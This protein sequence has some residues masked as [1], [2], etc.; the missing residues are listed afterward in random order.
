MKIIDVSLRRPVTVLILTIAILVLGL[1]SYSNMGVERM[2][3]IDF[4]IVV[5]QT[6][7]DGASPAIM[8]NDVTDVLEARINTIEGIKNISSSSYEG[9]SVI[10]VEFDL[11]R[12]V[13]F[14]AADV[15]GKV[16]M[17]KGQLP[18]ECDDPQVDKF[19]PSNMPIMNI[20]I[21]TDGHS[22]AKAVARFVDNV[23]TERLQT[24]T[25]VGGVQLAGFRDREIRIWLNTDSLEAY[26]LTTKDIK[27]AV[28]NRHVELPA[29]R[30]ET[31]TR[32][33]GIRLNGEYRSVAELSYVPVA[34]RNGAII[35]LRD[36]A[37]IED[38]VEDKRSQ[39][40]YEN[41]PTIMVQVRKQKGA[42]E[43]AL[44]SEV[45]KRIVELNEI[46]PR[47]S[48]LVIV[49]DTSR[50]ILRSM[51]G[52]RGDIILAIFLTSLIMF[53]F[54]RTI[55]A[56]IIAVITIP[57]CLLGS[58]AVLYWMG[59]TINNISMMGMSL[60]VGMVVDATSV[61]M[62]NISRHKAMGK[63]PMRAA[64]DGAGEVGFAVVA[65]A[66]TTLAVFIPIAFMRGVM[67][68]FFNAFGITVA[69]TI[70][71][72]L[73]L[74]LT[75]TPFLCSRILG[76][77]RPGF[78]QNALE[79]PF[80]M[81]ERGYR[82]LLSF[83]VNHRLIVILAALATF[84]GGIWIATTLGSE[85]TP[86]EDQGYFRL[87][88]EMP[89]DTS[90]EV[91]ERVMSEMISVVEADPRVAY[92]Y[93]VAGSG[94]GQEVYKGSLT[95]ELIPKDQR[96][97][98]SVIMGQLRRK[99]SAFRDVDIKMGNWGGSDITLMI[100][101]PTSESLAEIGDLIKSDLA[102][103]PRG[104]VDITTD[105][106]M[107]K[108]RINLELNRALADDLGV[109]IRDLSD[110]LNAWF[111]GTTSGSF[112]EGG[113]RYDIRIRAEKD[114][115]DDPDKVF[116]TLVRTAGGQV[117]R[118]DGL[119]TSSIG[120]SPNVIKRYNRQR[121]IQIGANVEGISPSEGIAIME[122]VFRKYAPQD[123]TYNMT[124]TGD[125]ERMRESFANMAIALVFA[126]ML[127]YIVMA[128][129][130]ESFLHP[131]TVMFSLP[132]MTAGSFGL[133]YLAN[134]RISVMSFMGII[135]LVGVVVNNAILLVDFI[136]QLRAGG[137]KKVEAVIESG[138]LRL[139]AILMTTVST[140]VGNLPVA[141]A[142]SEGGEIR[143][144]MSVAV[145]GGLFTSTLLTLLVIPVIYL[146]LDDIKDW[147]AGRIHRYR[148][149]RRLREMHSNRPQSSPTPA[150][151]SAAVAAK[152]MA[153]PSAA[154]VE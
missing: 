13:D 93:G 69:M 102:S 118:A 111:A 7:M 90:L 67:G 5:V 133:M 94:Q 150:G 18:D 9:R 128:I 51:N 16:S 49:S 42:N 147:V 149:Y 74:S 151:A 125:S 138:P 17:A 132:L 27:D 71:I 25:G 134:L 47:G 60:A 41:S 122:D 96:E 124:P 59:I 37:R 75:L 23:V 81:L 20:A 30:I 34:Y 50:F 56:T 72:S 107:N 66:A 63:N 44:A 152:E 2:P 95:I 99:L 62:E 121:S 139:R 11:D 130:F 104:L 4:P 105:L 43:V 154:T 131:F 24:V 106:Q 8:D 33:Y 123:G 141:L 83:A 32:E 55:R 39:S 73:L 145:T 15:R 61:V 64:S 116:N 85:F 22:D 68:R 70:V 10:V 52:V 26:G 79:A 127:V 1:Y 135:L 153:E 142:L 120:A 89:A 100:Q 92:T 140:M 108:P 144:P 28:Y 6:T 35:R 48:K 119:V 46:S 129:Q 136:N 103:D 115:R 29:G 98:A 112:N 126:I 114:S 57:V 76:R 80:L 137:M 40:L 78:V 148:A 87:N 86:N 36:V 54:L 110:E 58:V 101:G 3:N 117:I 45:R 91:T 65:G 82:R 38:D 113:Y 31:G 19:D 97:K 88:I 14:A 109:N 12:N 146:V 77:E 143:Q 84:S 21:E 53:I